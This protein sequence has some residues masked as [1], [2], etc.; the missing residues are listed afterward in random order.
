MKIMIVLGDFKNNNCATL[1]NWFGI[2]NETNDTK[3][4][5]GFSKVVFVLCNVLSFATP[6]YL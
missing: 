5:R 2:Y 4:T 6:K 3:K 1:H